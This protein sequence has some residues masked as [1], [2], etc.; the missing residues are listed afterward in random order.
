MEVRTVPL[1]DISP[2]PYQSRVT[3]DDEK[4]A[5]LRHQLMMDKMYVP[6][7]VRPDSKSGKYICVD[8]GRRIKIATSMTD[9]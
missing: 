7:I 8:G 5:A 1:R 4:D 3:V 6:P 9:Q 2:N